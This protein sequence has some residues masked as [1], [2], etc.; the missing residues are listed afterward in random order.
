[1]VFIFQELKRSIYRDIDLFLAKTNVS[2]MFNLLTVKYSKEVLKQNV[3]I[4]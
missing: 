2:R 1:M 3:F 4:T